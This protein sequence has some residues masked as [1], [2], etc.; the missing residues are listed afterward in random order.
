MVILMSR[1]R[2]FFWNIFYLP[3]NKHSKCL[4]IMTRK[5]KKDYIA[6][7]FHWWRVLSRI[8]S[9]NDDLNIL[10][11]GGGIR[12]LE[13]NQDI[14]ISVTCISG[15]F[16]SPG[17]CNVDERSSTWWD[18]PFGDSLQRGRHEGTDTM[19]LIPCFDWLDVDCASHAVSRRRQWA[20]CLMFSKSSLYHDLNE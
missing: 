1:V 16:P 3:W 9:Y 19:C 11:N 12:V 8:L 15:D 14:S 4:T 17:I 6:C 5:V 20:V 10:L 7:C 13:V 18:F 2:M